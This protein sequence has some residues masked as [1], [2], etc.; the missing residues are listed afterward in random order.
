MYGLV[1]V[2]VWMACYRGYSNRKMGTL[3]PSVP[4]IGLWRV[5]K[6]Y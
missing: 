5:A 1:I 4:E 2:C 6:T 3:S